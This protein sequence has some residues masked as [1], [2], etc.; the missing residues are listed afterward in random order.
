MTRTV[1][2]FMLRRFPRGTTLLEAVIAIG[3]ILVG[4]V[5]TLVLI[6]TTI[7]LG[8]ANQDRIVAQDLAREGMELAY[9]QRNS[10]SL[11]KVLF[12]GDAWD[13]YFS[14]PVPKSAIAGFMDTYPKKYNIGDYD[15]GTCKV[16]DQIDIACADPNNQYCTDKD[17][18]LIENN[19][20]GMK[21][22]IEALI[23]YIFGNYKKLPPRCD[24]AS[25][26][27]VVDS[28]WNGS[29]PEHSGCNFS[30]DPNQ[31]ANIVDAVWLVQELMQS[32]YPLQTAFPTVNSLSSPPTEAWKFFNP[33]DVVGQGS[34]NAANGSFA[35]QDAWDYKTAPN[36]EKVSRVFEKN[37]SF[38][39]NT[40]ENSSTPSK[41][42]R[43]T[44]FQPICRGTNTASG[45]PKVE[46]EVIP[47]NV[48]FN[49]SRYLN[50]H[51]GWSDPDSRTATSIGSLVTTEVR[52]PTPA[53]SSAHVIYQEYL[54]D[55]LNI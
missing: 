49:C 16:I 6:N 12:P 25:G 5:G 30:P 34:F 8:R 9:A 7:R 23:L 26:Q 51:K 28:W 52:W 44:T 45:S 19:P 39:Q 14:E 1:K 4:V 32:T 43:L 36:T 50:T 40:S 42:Y 24:E 29:T 20:E 3:V 11:G 21:C 2:L 41:F 33:S 35:L 47:R 18:D 53:A 17:D 13:K 22:D 55:W 31:S 48:I 38:I 46:I 10:G 54:Y 37:N 27:T 15:G